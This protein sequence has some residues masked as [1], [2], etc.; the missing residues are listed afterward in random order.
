VKSLKGLTKL[1]ILLDKRAMDD[2]G[3]G[4]DCG[5]PSLSHGISSIRDEPY[6]PL[7]QP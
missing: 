7:P 6:A 4:N 2:V 5:S 1:E 3:I